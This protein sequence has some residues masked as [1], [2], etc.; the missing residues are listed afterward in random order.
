[1]PSDS[2][3]ARP[4]TYLIFLITAFILTV[5][6][7]LPSGTVRQESSS[8]FSSSTPSGKHGEVVE[9]WCPLPQKPKVAKDG[10]R[11]STLFADQKSVDMQAKRLSAAINVPTVSVNGGG[12]VLTDPR[13][14][15]FK[16]F[17]KVLDG[18]FPL[19]YV[20]SSFTKIGLFV[21]FANV[22]DLDTTT[23]TS[24]WT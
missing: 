15:V 4:R 10:L 22:L 8:P 13:Y 20:L 21:G 17:H 16:K 14:E 19:V 6:W 7:T 24:N 1:M 18:L 9:S 3:W 5:F 11:P 23:R 2:I 12:D